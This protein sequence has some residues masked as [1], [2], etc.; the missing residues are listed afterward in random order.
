MQR[1]GQQLSE[2]HLAL[3]ETMYHATSDERHQVLQE[4]EM[5]LWRHSA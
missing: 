3:Y 4:N 5:R 1:R 2:E